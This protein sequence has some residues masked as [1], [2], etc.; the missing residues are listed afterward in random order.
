MKIETGTIG[1]FR[2]SMFSK[3]KVLYSGM[4]TTQTFALSPIVDESFLT[5]GF[6]F[7]PIIYYSVESETISI[8]EEKFQVKRIEANFIELELKKKAYT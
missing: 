6:K 7:A 5:D 3:F 1:V 2:K 4:P 8:L